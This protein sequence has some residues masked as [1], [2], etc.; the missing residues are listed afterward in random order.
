MGLVTGKIKNIE[1]MSQGI[2]SKN[3]LTIKPA[4]GG[5]VFIEF[6]GA[7]KKVSDAFNLDEDVIIEHSYDGKTSQNGVVFNNLPGISIKKI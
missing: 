7:M 6:R 2:H 1:D 3:R 4:E 5:L